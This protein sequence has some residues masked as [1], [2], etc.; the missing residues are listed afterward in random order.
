MVF[1]PASIAHSVAADCRTGHTGAVTMVKTAPIVDASSKAET[2]LPPYDCG[3]TG[4]GQPESVHRRS[5][6]EDRRSA[7]C[8]CR[9]AGPAEPESRPR[10]RPSRWRRKAGPPGH[11]QECRPGLRAPSPACPRSPTP[12]AAAP[13]SEPPATASSPRSCRRFPSR[14]SPKVHG[15]Q[16]WAEYFKYYGS[17]LAQDFNTHHSF[18]FSQ[19]G[20]KLRSNTYVPACVK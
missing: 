3:I 13:A 17:L 20:S 9:P 7:S 10:V 14:H 15:G 4:D 5:D 19:P 11:P 1:D 6:T 12:L 8:R 18:G 16:R 2:A